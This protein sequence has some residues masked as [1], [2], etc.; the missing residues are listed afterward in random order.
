MSDRKHQNRTIMKTGK[1]SLLLLF[2]SFT[3]LPAATHAQSATFV[4]GKAT[5]VGTIRFSSVQD[6]IT[7]REDLTAPGVIKNALSIPAKRIQYDVIN[8]GQGTM[9]SWTVYYSS[10]EGPKNCVGVMGKGVAQGFKERFPEMF[11]DYAKRCER[12]EVHP[13]KP[14]PYRDA[15]GVLIVKRAKPKQEVAE[16]DLLEYI[17]NWKKAWQ[18]DE[19]KR[20]VADAIRNLVMLGWM[21]LQFS[22]SLPE[23]I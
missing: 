18:T 19:K 4:R 16:Q 3:A 23:A 21:R 22:E 8:G 11:E 6:S 9:S 13:G 17:L 5:S 1:Y 20:A 15:S 14:Y 10:S 2:F 7:I 12:K